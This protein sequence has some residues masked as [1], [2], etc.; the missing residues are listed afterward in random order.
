MGGP[1]IDVCTGA[2]NDEVTALESCNVFLELLDFFALPGKS[3]Q[4]LHQSWLEHHQCI[5]QQAYSNSIRF[6]QKSQ[7][8]FEK[9]RLPLML[10]PMVDRTEIPH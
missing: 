8:A 10:F 4:S 3:I 2:P 7:S 9:H 5:P 6:C 1:I